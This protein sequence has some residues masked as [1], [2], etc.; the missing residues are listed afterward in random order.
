MHFLSEAQSAFLNKESVQPEVRVT[1][2]HKAT[3]SCEVADSK[4]DVKWYKDGKL[5]PSS[6][7]VHTETKGKGRQLVIDSVEKKD[8][9]EYTCETGMEKLVFRVQVEGKVRVHELLLS[10]W[11]III[12]MFQQW[13]K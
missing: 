2:S 4:T 10:V 5:V 1:L 11:H 8:V 13:M 12:K 7:T 3:L 9:G 6:K